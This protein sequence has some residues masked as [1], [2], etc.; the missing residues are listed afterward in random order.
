LFRHGVGATFGLD[1]PSP[2]WKAGNS[3]RLAAF[4]LFESTFY[5][6]YGISEPRRFRGTS[7]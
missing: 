6:L 4:A 5:G 2:P 1:W 7:Q 3:S